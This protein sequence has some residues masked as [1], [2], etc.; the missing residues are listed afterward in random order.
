MPLKTTSQTL[1]DLLAE[2]LTRD[3]VTFYNG[4]LKPANIANVDC[5]ILT[6]EKVS[7]ETLTE[8]TGTMKDNVRWH[9]RLVLWIDRKKYLDNS[10]GES[11]QKNTVQEALESIVEGLDDDMN[12]KSDTI[13]GVLRKNL[14]IEGKIFY[15]YNVKANYENYIDEKEYQ[16]AKAI[17]EFDAERRV[18]RPS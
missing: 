10:T 14:S 3:I 8:G 1:F 18:T 6:I 15:N 2:K 7:T 16:L 11:E 4:E 9:Y 17:I 12:Y 5:P 13:F